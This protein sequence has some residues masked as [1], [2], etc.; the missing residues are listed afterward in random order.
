MDGDRDRLAPVATRASEPARQR[1]LTENLGQVRP[2][3]KRWP[4]QR[5][6][7]RDHS[8]VVA[9]RAKWAGPPAA[10]MPIQATRTANHKSIH[11]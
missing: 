8:R 7:I 10:T 11:E 9:D 4:D 1:P 5:A 3:N 6:A 2:I